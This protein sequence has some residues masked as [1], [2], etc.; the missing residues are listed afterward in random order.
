MPL[1]QIQFDNGGMDKWSF[2]HF[3]DHV[4]ILQAIKKQLNIS[5]QEWPIFPFTPDSPDVWLRMHQAMHF[6]MNN[7]LNISG[8]SLTEVNFDNRA[9]VDAFLDMNYLEHS[10]AR[11]ALGI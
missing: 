8:S 10:N 9:E 5:L 11:E 6:D 1:P 3:Q 2:D 4:E 7:A